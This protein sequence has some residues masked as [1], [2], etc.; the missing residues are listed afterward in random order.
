MKGNKCTFGLGN[1]PSITLMPNYFNT[2]YQDKYLFSEDLTDSSMYTDRKNSKTIHSD[3][4]KLAQKSRL[5]RKRKTLSASIKIIKKLETAFRTFYLVRTVHC[6]R[7]TR[8]RTLYSCVSLV[9][10]R[11]RGNW[12]YGITYLLG[13]ILATEDWG[14]FAWNLLCSLGHIFYHGCEH[15]KVHEK[16]GSSWFQSGVHPAVLCLAAHSSTQL[17]RSWCNLNVKGPRA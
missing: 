11:T 14:S 4:C 17:S 8:T 15:A 2:W 5:T 9:S 1:S 12:V 7:R 13:I 10:H 6:A 16:G 3:D